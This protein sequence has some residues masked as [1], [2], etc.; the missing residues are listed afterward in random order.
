MRF[1]KLLGKCL[2]GVVVLAVVLYGIAVAI[3]WRDQP[4]SAD[5]VRLQKVLADRPTVAAGDNGFVYMLGMATAEGDPQ[6][7]GEARYQW[8]EA[9]NADLSKANADPQRVGLTPADTHE[10]TVKRV[11]D[12]C[13]RT[14][15]DTCPAAFD[16]AVSPQEWSS[17]DRL[18]LERYRNLLTRKAW[19]EIVP[20]DVSAPMPAYSTPV[21]AQRLYLLSLRGANPATLKQGLNDDLAHWRLMLA[22]T[23]TLISKMIAVAGV[24]QNLM[25]GNLL[26][27]RVAREQMNA[28]IP[29]SWRAPMSRA[30]LSMERPI[31]GEYVF[32]SSIY[33]NF[34]GASLLDEEVAY[35]PQ[36]H[37]F[38]VRVTTMLMRPLYQEQD[39]INLVTAN[40]TDMLTT[41]DIPLDRYLAT[42]E[43]F[44]YQPFRHPFGSRV[45][46]AT[47]DLTRQVGSADLSQYFVRAAYTEAWRRGA[48][49]VAELR[50]TGVEAPA[51]PEALKHAT[52]VNPFDGLPFG[53]NTQKTAVAVVGAGKLDWLTQHYAY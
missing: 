7:V 8:L 40:Y 6:Q 22:N 49:L 16:A 26:L 14:P 31:A 1:L 44:P 10:P 25:F 3:N 36:K 13:T 24:R 28:A 12:E 32:V 19:R 51:V 27:R 37:P 30:E 17:P 38:T 43:K 11:F 53:W 21:T 42:A 48:L 20:A 33:R 45:Y 18:L 39:V 15:S 23:D 29:E 52:L 35:E 4:P 5:V 34:S 2:L 9:V 50:A 47:G 41:F 46:D